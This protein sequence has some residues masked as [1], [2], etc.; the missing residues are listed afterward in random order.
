MVQEQQLQFQVHQQPM[1]AEEVEE[2]IPK[3][4]EELEEL[5]V[6]LQ[7]EPLVQI[8]MEQQIQEVVLQVMLVLEVQ[9]L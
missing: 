1:L 4:V 8:E 6:E 5:E 9:E 3:V 2:L 7:V